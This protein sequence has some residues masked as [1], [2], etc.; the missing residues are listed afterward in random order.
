MIAQNVDIVIYCYDWITT[1][2]AGY[3]Q[4]RFS[5]FSHLILGFAKKLARIK[6]PSIQ[7]QLKSRCH[8]T[9]HIS[10]VRKMYIRAKTSGL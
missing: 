8:Q 9:A 4:L 10:V 5:F 1:D 7:I 6:E 2:H 3:K